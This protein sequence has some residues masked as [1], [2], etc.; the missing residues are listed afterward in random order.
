MVV[1]KYMEKM[2][3]F[4]LPYPSSISPSMA[5]LQALLSKLP[6][7]KPSPSP[8]TPAAAAA[9]VED[10]GVGAHDGPP[11]SLFFSY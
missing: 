11:P 10:D 5:S 6:S 9:A 2:A 3:G 7:V 1:R 4:L 8:P